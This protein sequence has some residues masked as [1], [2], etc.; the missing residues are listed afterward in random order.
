[1]LLTHF[2]SIHR[3]IEQH[4]FRVTVSSRSMM[5]LLLELPLADTTLVGLG[6]LDRRIRITIANKVAQ[7]QLSV[8]MWNEPKRLYDAVDI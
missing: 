2:P 1:M 5:M 8:L 3:L 6:W 4:R 7:K